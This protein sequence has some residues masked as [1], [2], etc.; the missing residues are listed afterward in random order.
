M[1]SFEVQLSKVKYDI[2]YGYLPARQI[3]NLNG[4]E[5]KEGT[6]TLRWDPASKAKRQVFAEKYIN[7]YNKIAKQFYNRL[8]QSLQEQG[9]QDP[10]VIS[11]GMVKSRFLQHL[12]VELQKDPS[13][14]IACIGPGCSRLWW[15]QQWDWQRVPCVALDSVNMFPDWETLTTEESVINKWTNKPK[16]FRLGGAEIGIRGNVHFD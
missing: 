9:C 8:A 13:K 4:P 3:Y 7:K 16:G 6:P 11:A 15:L 1:D 5:F 2:K 14:I 10:I 12:P